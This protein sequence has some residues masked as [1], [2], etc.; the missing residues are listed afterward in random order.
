MRNCTVRHA[1]VKGYQAPGE[2]VDKAPE[3]DDY[4]IDLVTLQK[5]YKVKTDPDLDKTKGGTLDFDKQYQRELKSFR[6]FLNK[7]P[8]YKEMISS[9]KS[10]EFVGSILTKFKSSVSKNDSVDTTKIQQMCDLFQNDRDLLQ[11]IN[12]QNDRDQFQ[13]ILRIFNKPVK[14]SKNAEELSNKYPTNKKLQDL[15]NKKSSLKSLEKEI[16][17]RSINHNDNSDFLKKFLPEIT[18]ETEDLSQLKAADIR[19]KYSKLYEKKPIKSDLNLESIE[20]FL[21][22]LKKSNDHHKEE[23]FRRQKAYEWSKLQLSNNTPENGRFFQPKLVPGTIIPFQVLNPFNRSSNDLLFPEFNSNGKTQREYLILT[24]SG[25]TLNCGYENP[26]GFNFIPKD[27]FTIL[28]NL[29]KPETFIK[30]IKKL[31]LQNWKLIGGGDDKM[32]VF[33]RIAKPRLW[34]KFLKNCF[35]AI[36]M[37]ST[38]LVFG[39]FFIHDLNSSK[40]FITSPF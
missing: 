29:E 2:K 6:E 20:L 17:T 1:S 21:K 9:D 11:K 39:S 31:S 15:T 35:T 26:F 33:S 14:K 38:G 36:G 13:E 27:I 24:S 10:D 32:L 28:N 16:V 30:P 8:G 37:V 23:E 7:T 25:K 4:E 5:K 3:N 12:V 18:T 22:K 34:W 19:D 40:K